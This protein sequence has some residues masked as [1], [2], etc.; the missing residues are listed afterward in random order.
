MN[1]RT[2][3]QHVTCNSVTVLDTI[4]KNTKEVEVTLSRFL[5]TRG[6]RKCIMGYYERT[7][8]CYFLDILEQS[9][10]FFPQSGFWPLAHS[11]NETC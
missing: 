9:Q 7:L 1:E 8:R 5:S 10:D 2:F 3:C 4:G 11:V 6:K